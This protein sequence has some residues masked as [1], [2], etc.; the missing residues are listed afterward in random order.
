L[1]CFYQ[2]LFRLLFSN[3]FFFFCSALHSSLAQ[4]LRALPDPQGPQP[5]LLTQARHH[6]VP[7][8]PLPPL[9]EALQVRGARPLHR[10]ITAR[11]RTLSPLLRTKTPAPATSALEKK[12][13]G[14]RNLWFLPSQKRRRRPRRLPPPE[15]CRKLPR[16]LP[17]TRVT[18]LALPLLQRPFQRHRRKLLA[19]SQ[20]VL[21]QRRCRPRP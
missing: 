20:L 12:L 10:Q 17:P 8:T 1:F 4:G 13:P 14:G 7:A 5:L 11:R 3:P 2:V 16:R 9:W 19:P 21:L 6:L 15:L 18:R